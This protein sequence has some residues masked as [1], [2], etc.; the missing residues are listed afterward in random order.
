MFVNHDAMKAVSMAL[1]L[2]CTQCTVKTYCL[3]EYTR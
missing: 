3:C 1:R 2:G